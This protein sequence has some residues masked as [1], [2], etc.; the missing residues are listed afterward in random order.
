LLNEE[1]KKIGTAILKKRLD[2][3][4]KNLSDISPGLLFDRTDKVL[5]EQGTKQDN[6]V[7]MTI[8]K[9]EE[10]ITKQSRHIIESNETSKSFL[11]KIRDLNNQLT[12]QQEQSGDEEDKKGVK[13][14][15]CADASAGRRAAYT[16][17]TTEILSP[18]SIYFWGFTEFF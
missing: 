7:I 6:D 12:L 10:E 9:Y 2:K 15:L 5:K 16:F 18:I 8:S 3:L 13:P 14:F 1:F 4:S 17:G 11:D